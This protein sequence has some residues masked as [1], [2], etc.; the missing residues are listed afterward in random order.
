[1]SENNDIFENQ[2]DVAE[3]IE[4]SAEAMGISREAVSMKRKRVMVA[5]NNCKDCFGKGYQEIMPPNSMEFM[6]R[7]CKCI[8]IRT[9]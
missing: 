6:R 5:R 8:R 9:I 1:M 2:G 7:P 4:E 3:N